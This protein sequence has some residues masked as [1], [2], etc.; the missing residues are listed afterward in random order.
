MRARRRERV[1]WDAEIRKTEQIRR[2][3]FVM[4]FLSFAVAAAAIV[5][6]GR[7][8]GAEIDLPRRALSV[9]LIMLACL[10]LGATLRHRARVKREREEAHRSEEDE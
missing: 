4:S 7:M 3:G 9:A 5:G 6:A 10:V 1:D 8:G 2:R